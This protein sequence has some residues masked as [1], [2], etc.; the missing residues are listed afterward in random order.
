MTNEDKDPGIVSAT[1]S[2]AA[3]K[4]TG[5]PWAAWM[6]LL[7]EAGGRTDECVLGG[8]ADAIGGS[9]RLTRY[10]QIALQRRDNNNSRQI[11]RINVPPRATYPI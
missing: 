4:G 10:S 7:D 2:E 6:A 9:G 11:M 5:K 3:E 1:S 8:G